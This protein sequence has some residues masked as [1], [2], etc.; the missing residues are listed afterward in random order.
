MSTRTVTEQ[1]FRLPE[2]RN[3]KVEDYEIRSDGKVVRK[4]RW[5][6]GIYRIVSLVGMSR[7]DFEID[8]V[9]DAVRALLLPQKPARDAIEMAREVY[10]SEPMALQ[11][12][13]YLQAVLDGKPQA[14]EA[15]P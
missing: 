3:A 14:T 8:A 9:V 5:E 13:D 15:A 12:L 7:R 11:C 4:D 1:D 6:D 10:E 2:F